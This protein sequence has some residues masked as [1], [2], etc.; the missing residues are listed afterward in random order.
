MRFN[1][2]S[3]V[4]N[5]CQYFAI[6][7]YQRDYEW[8]KEE[9]STLL[10]DLFIVFNDSSNATHFFG[11]IVTVPFDVANS[12]A[13]S[14]KFEEYGIETQSRDNIKHIVDGQQ[15]LTSFSLL[16]LAVRD[17]I[18]DPNNNFKKDYQDRIVNDILKPILYGKEYLLEDDC[19]RSPKIILNG[20]TGRGYLELL[21]GNDSSTVNHKLKGVKR[22]KTAYEFFKNELISRCKCL[23]EEGKIDNK[24]IF[25]KKFVGIVT[26]KIS[27][28]EIECEES[29]DAF[30]VFDSLNGKGLDLTAADR[31]K[32]IFISWCSDGKGIKKWERLENLVGEDS[33]TNF[34]L[35]LFFFHEELRISKNKLPNIFKSNYQKSA[36]ND[37]DHF[38]EDL[39]QSAELYSKLKSAT[40]CDKDLN[41]ILR[42]FKSLK[43][44]QVY[45][46]LFAAFYHFKDDIYNDKSLVKFAKI[47]LTLFVRMQVAEIGMNKLD[48]LFSECIR[49]LKKES[50][51]LQV[52]G[53]YIS[54]YCSKTVPDGVFKLQFI[55]FAPKD[56]GVSKVYMRYLEGYLRM[57]KGNREQVDINEITLE[58][59]VPQQVDYDKW[60]NGAVIPDEYTD[61]IKETVIERI[62][63]KALIYGDDNSAASNNLYS[64]KLMVYKDGKMGQNQGTP[65]GTFALIKDIV[66][67]YP[68]KFTHTE[69]EER[70][71]ILADYAVEV[72]SV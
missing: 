52:V 28:V 58:H 55:N 42:D 9:N 31:I 15:R 49:K 44:E 64:E 65:Y 18:N 50:A 27:F 13:S 56:S 53:N 14:I 62:A 68:N 67:Q 43:M 35:V 10:E 20:N 8:T 66:D 24:E 51:S 39:Y 29:V 33:L 1:S 59:I 21:T 37:Y 47:L 2:L 16:C 12:N 54:Q 71:K 5:N 32:N 38:A 48:S 19:T 57:K 7:D 6:P 46:M 30:Q 25:Y 4:M 3:Q 70:A 40:T 72:W 22:I 11:A 34:F 23:I 41:L 60:C 26:G 69:I 45:V 36:M 63:N 17:I 61:N